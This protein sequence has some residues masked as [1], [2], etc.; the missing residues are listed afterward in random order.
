MQT[1]NELIESLRDWKRMTRSEILL[2]MAKIQDAI[3][4]TRHEAAPIE[5]K[6][7]ELL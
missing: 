7:I 5:T 6:Q 2:T 3:N 1:L 4:A